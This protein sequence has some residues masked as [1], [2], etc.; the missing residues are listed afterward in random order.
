MIYPQTKRLDIADEHFGQTIVD[1]YRWLEADA[2]SDP[3]VAARV[4]AQNRITRAHLAELPGRDMLRKRLI[5][6]FDH[7]RYT[8]PLNEAGAISSRATRG[9]TTSPRSSCARARTGATACCSTHWSH[10]GTTAL[11]ERSPSDDGRRVA[12][13]MQEIGTDWRTIRVLDIESGATL[14]DTVEWA[15]FTNIAWASDGRGFFYSRFPEPVDKAMLGARGAG[16]AV[17]FHALGT[18]QQGDRLVHATPDQPH[19]VHVAGVTED[20]R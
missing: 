17:Y 4:S 16:H 3:E 11:A 9:W 6:L 18:S 14:E 13:A 2:H 7:P 8:A 1:P 15:R 19:L 5:S 12:F 10:G 20:G